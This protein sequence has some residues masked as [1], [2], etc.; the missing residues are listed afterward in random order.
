MSTVENTEGRSENR[1]TALVLT[2]LL[3]VKAQLIADF[4]ALKQELELVRQQALTEGIR[5]KRMYDRGQTNLGN[6]FI[7]IMIAAIIAI[8][9]FIPTVQDAIASSN[10][11]GTTKT[12]L[13]MLSLFAALLLLISLAS[14]LMRRA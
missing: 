2:Y 3:A 14:P 5:Q 7:G 6:L 1:V 12:I 9:V 13:D 4:T 10:V 11:S 8:R